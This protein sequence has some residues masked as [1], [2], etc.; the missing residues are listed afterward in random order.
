MDFFELEKIFFGV[1]IFGGYSFDVKNS[2]LLIYDVSSA[3]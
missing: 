3:F 2:N 1:E